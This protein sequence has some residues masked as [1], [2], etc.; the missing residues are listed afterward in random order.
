MFHQGLAN[1]KTVQAVTENILMQ[2]D[3]KIGELLR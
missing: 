3:G 2:Q 1:A